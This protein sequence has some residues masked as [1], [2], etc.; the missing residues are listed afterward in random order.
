MKAVILG[1]AGSTRVKYKNYRPFYG[2]KSLTDIL[3]EKL[4]EVMDPE[5]IFLSCEDDRFRAFAEKWKIHFILRDGEFTKLA[6]NTVEVVR[7]VCKDVPGSDDI[8]YCSCMDPLFDSY[9]EIFKIWEIE[10][11]THDSLNVIYPIKNY[12]LDQNHNPI[13][14]GFGY[15]HKYSQYI[16]P[17]YQI[18]WAT[19]ILTRKSIETCGYMVGENPYWYDAYNPTIDIDTERDWELAQVLY[20]YYHEHDLK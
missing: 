16:P 19:E 20:K 15:W 2:E 17:I 14:F 11:A 13:G 10:K 8:L 18:S 6:T 3:L 1:K 4:T 12:F 5:D 7:N 9:D